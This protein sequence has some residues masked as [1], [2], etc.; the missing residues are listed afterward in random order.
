MGPRV[1]FLSVYE[2]GELQRVTQVEYQLNN[3]KTKRACIQHNII[4]HAKMNTVEPLI[5][6]SPRSGQPLYSGQVPSYRLNLA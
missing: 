6:D 5:T 3:N 1:P 4:V 2:A